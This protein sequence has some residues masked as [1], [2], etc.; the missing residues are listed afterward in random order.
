VFPGNR[1]ANVARKRS[2]PSAELG[3]GERRAAGR[4]GLKL[5]AAD[6]ARSGRSWGA[7]LGGGVAK[8]AGSAELLLGALPATAAQSWRDR[9]SFTEM[10]VRNAGGG[11]LGGGWARARSWRAGRSCFWGWANGRGAK[12]HLTAHFWR[13]G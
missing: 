7:E 6:R 12:L 8:L 4:S 1:G 10:P 13:E 9:R 11:K 5:A 3:V 2:W